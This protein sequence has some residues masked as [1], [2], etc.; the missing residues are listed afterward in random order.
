MKH[1][2]IIMLIFSALAAHA[3]EKL[4]KPDFSKSI[5]H[6]SPSTIGVIH[7]GG[8]SNT[9]SVDLKWKPLLTKKYD[10]VEHEEPNQELIDS[11]KEMK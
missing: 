2:F 4:Q 8:S 6:T 10:E 11:I 9:Q 7:F 1:I 3:Q 5:Y